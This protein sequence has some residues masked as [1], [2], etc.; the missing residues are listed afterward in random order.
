M[1]NFSLNQENYLEQF[2]NVGNKL[3]T[4]VDFLKDVARYN[5]KNKR[6]KSRPYR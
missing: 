4:I 5:N 3:V 2:V 1:E 6:I